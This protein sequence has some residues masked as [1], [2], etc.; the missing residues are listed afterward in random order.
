MAE[1]MAKLHI[2]SESMTSFKETESDRTK[3]LYMCEEMRKLQ[4][5]SILPQSL[6]S[7]INRPCTALVL[8]TPPQRVMASDGSENNN[9]DSI[10]DHNRAVSEVVMESDMNNMD[11]DNV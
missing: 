10:P 6:L 1:H 4:Q 5:D 11:L 7:R 8:W 3:R 9:E 2:S